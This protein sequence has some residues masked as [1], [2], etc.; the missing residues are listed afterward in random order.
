MNS[1]ITGYAGFLSRTA[2]GGDSSFGSMA[3]SS[4][5]SF[6]ANYGV[7]LFCSLIGS[8]IISG[9]VYAM[10]Q[11]YAT[12]ENGLR[13]ITLNDFKENLVR[14]V[15]KCIHISLFFI[16]TGIIFVGIAA[17]LAI[18]V[19]VASLFVTIP[20]LILLFL[21]LI[22]F[23]MLMPVYI[24]ERDMRF[25]NA[26]KK[27]WKLGTETLGGMVGLIIVLSIISSVIQTLTTLPWYITLLFGHV[28]S[29]ITESALEQSVSYKFALYILGLIQT[30]GAYAASTIGIIGLAFHY[31]HAREKV[32]GVTVDSNIS[33]FNRL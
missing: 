7:I 33:N 6:F 4:A 1:F 3:G 10:M 12:R 15:W 8:A 2:S 19:S 18:S 26:I 30:Y 11:T 20:V 16:L 31:F 28:F 27:A 21:F 13:H 29:L 32:E 25:S 5:I 9:M 24:F 14:N 22:P 17:I 23:M